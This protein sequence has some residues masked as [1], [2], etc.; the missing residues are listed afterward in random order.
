MTLTD[1]ILDHIPKPAAGWAVYR[2][3]APK[4]TEKPPW[5]IET[6]TTNGHIVGETQ[7]VHCGIGTLLVRIVS[8]TADSVNVLAD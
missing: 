1:T 6:V 7:Q 5:V 2:Q 4:P 8:T 3:T